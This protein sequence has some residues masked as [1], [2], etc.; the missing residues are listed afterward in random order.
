MKAIKLGLYSAIFSFLG[1]LADGLCGVLIL[2]LLQGAHC[3]LLHIQPRHSEGMR[4]YTR[5]ASLYIRPLYGLINTA[6]M[7][8]LTAKKDLLPQMRVVHF[9]VEITAFYVIVTVFFCQINQKHVLHAS[10]VTL[11]CYFNKHFL[12]C[13][14][15]RYA[16]M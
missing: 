10:E 8:A 3:E 13:I 16:G 1:M 12:Q 9:S 5:Q 7:I 14:D 4:T 6:K 2:V 11:F 15:L